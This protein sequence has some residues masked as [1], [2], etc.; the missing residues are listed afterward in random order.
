M[1]RFRAHARSGSERN[2]DGRHRFEHWYRDRTVYFITARCRDRFPAFAS[3][4]AKRI[5]WDRFDHYTR[6][7]GFA[8]WVTTLI[9]NHYHTVGYLFEGKRLGPMM[10]RIHGSVAK[11][12]NDQLQAQSFER[13][14][15]FWRGSS[16]GDYF[17]GCLRSEKQYRLAYRYTLLQSERHRVCSDHRRYAHTRVAVSLE[18]GLE[19]ALRT[20]AFMD[21]VRYPRYDGPNRPLKRADRTGGGREI[22]EPS[23]GL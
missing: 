9:A 17:D 2:D 22:D 10:Q 7:H 18:D 11:L 4:E 16:N 21:G 1:R 14:T 13:L 20:R 23:G 19:F 5:F 8:P 12:V 6:E 3:E 15:P